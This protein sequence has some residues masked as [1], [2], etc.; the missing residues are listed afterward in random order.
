LSTTGA[1]ATVTVDSA[2]CRAKPR[3]NGERITFLYK[4][5]QLDI[6]GKNDDPG[7]P[8]WYVQIPDSKSNCW[9]WGKTAQVKGNI[10][11]IPVVP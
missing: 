6:V 10:E 9:L 3:A 5:Q 4:D 8:W 1:T 7:N 2:N 11:E